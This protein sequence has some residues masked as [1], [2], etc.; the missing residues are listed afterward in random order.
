MDGFE[1]VLGFFK[2][3]FWGFFLGE[4]WQQSKEKFLP[5]VKNDKIPVWRA[6]CAG[7][8]MPGLS[9]GAFPRQHP[10][11]SLLSFLGRIWG[12]RAAM[13]MDE[14]SA[15]SASC[16]PPGDGGELCKFCFLPFPF[17]DNAERKQLQILVYSN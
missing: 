14:N 7:C 17:H 6:G 2:E 3:V 8:S 15:N 16:L 4:S 10:E 11:I 5:L 12:S 1:G 13:E 9:P